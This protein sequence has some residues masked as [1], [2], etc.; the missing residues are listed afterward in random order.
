MS[1]KIDAAILEKIDVLLNQLS[2]KEKVSL[3]AGKNDWQTMDIPRLGIP[4]ITMTDGPHGV[5]ADDKVP[6]RIMSPATSFPNGI[7]LASTWNI[8][9]VEKVGQALGEETHAMGCD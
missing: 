5:R 7:A 1:A 9:L 8:E 4:S 2:L 6:S 3:L